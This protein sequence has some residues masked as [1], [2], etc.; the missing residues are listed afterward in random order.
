MLMSTKPTKPIKH[1]LTLAVDIGGTGIKLDSL[2]DDGRPNAEFQRKATPR[3]ATPESILAVIEELAKKERPFDRIAV[4]F[5]G[6]VKKGVVLTAPNLHK[7]WRNFPLED[8][9]VKKFGKPARVANDAAVQGYGA[10]DGIGLELVITLGTGLG[11]SLF[12]HGKLA[13]SLEMA[14]HPFRKGKTYEDLLGKKALDKYGAKDWNKALREAIENWFNLFHY[15]QLY[16]GGGNTKHIKGEL[17]VNSKI[18]PNTNG[19]YGGVKLW[20]DS[21]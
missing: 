6:V 16:I 5:P 19:I 3:P 11:S 4:G 10:V 18:T 13:A 2:N 7:S 9:L 1:P 20:E 17:P 15:D 12:Q 21:Y 8:A 14:H